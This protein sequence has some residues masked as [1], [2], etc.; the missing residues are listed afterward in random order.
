MNKKEGNTAADNITLEDIDAEALWKEFT[1]ALHNGVRAYKGQYNPFGTNIIK[2]QKI[3]SKGCT[4]KIES[5]ETYK[6]G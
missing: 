4:Y 6:C 5:K 2:G 1:R 3:S